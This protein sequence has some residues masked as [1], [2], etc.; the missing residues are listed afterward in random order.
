MGQL[1]LSGLEFCQV[2]KIKQESSKEAEGII[3]GRIL[4]WLDFTSLLIITAF[5]NAFIIFQTTFNKKISSGFSIDSCP[6]RKPVTVQ[7]FPQVYW[8]IISI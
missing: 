5:L 3:K 8:D 1:V 6:M 7:F 2:S 4:V